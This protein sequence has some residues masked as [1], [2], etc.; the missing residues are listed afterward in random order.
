[1]LLEVT[2]R[3]DESDAVVAQNYLLKSTIQQAFS[4]IGLAGGAF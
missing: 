3:I 4:T 2:L 1:M